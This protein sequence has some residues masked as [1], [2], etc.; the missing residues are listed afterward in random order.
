[1]ATTSNL[2]AAQ[3]EIIQRR[4][5]SL[6]AEKKKEEI[7]L[8]P[9]LAAR[10][11]GGLSLQAYNF[12]SN[13]LKGMKPYK[14]AKVAG[15]SEST[16]LCADEYLLQNPRIVK[17]LNRRAAR[18]IKTNDLTD[19]KIIAEAQKLAFWNLLDYG[20]IDEKGEFKI[21]LTRLTRDAAAAITEFRYDQNGRP[22][23]KFAD[24]KSSLEFLARIRKLLSSS[25]EKKDDDNKIDSFDSI[26][27]LDAVLLRNQ[28]IT[29]NNFNFNT[30]DSNGNERV[31][32][33][34]DLLLEEDNGSPS[35]RVVR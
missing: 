1:M 30:P 7:Q 24:K 33:S 25:E 34:G 19:Q 14:A 22:V 12:V 23:I 15:Y 28:N 20:E 10:R 17:E 29:I 6:P 18:W 35:R 3:D 2:V 11:K 13:F 31:I 26:K 21:D 9:A 5:I 16:C 27:A 4:P 8:A 32:D